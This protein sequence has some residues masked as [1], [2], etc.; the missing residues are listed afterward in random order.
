MT[1]ATVLTEHWQATPSVDI[2]PFVYRREDYVGTIRHLVIIAVDLAVIVFVVFPLGIVPAVVAE[3]MSIRSDKFAVVGPLFLTWMYLAVLKPS[4]FRS[5]GYWVTGS[6]IVTIYG[7]KPSTLRMTIRLAATIFWFSLPLG[8]FLIDFIWPTVDEEHQMLRDLYCGTR[9]IRSRA[10]PIAQ[11]R[12]V[13]SFYT[14]MGYS[15]MYSS[16]QKQAKEQAVCSPP[17]EVKGKP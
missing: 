10:T 16:V 14:A 5:P 6:K 3:S 13:H 1:S 9:M 7:Q 11:G 17:P 15:L 12:I 4:R 8:T 2:G